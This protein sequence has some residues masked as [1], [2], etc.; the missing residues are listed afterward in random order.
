[1]DRRVLLDSTSLASRSLLGD[2]E[3]IWVLSPVDDFPLTPP[4]CLGLIWSTH[5]IE[6]QAN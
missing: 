2:S 6:V 3:G 5:L 1:M 4:E